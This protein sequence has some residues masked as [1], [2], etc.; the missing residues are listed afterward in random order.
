MA[1]APA[2]TLLVIGA[3]PKALALVAKRAILRQ[4]GFVV[5]RLLLIE[6]HDIAAH[7]AGVHGYT[8]GARM[9]GTAP[10]KDV[11]F[12]YDSTCWGDVEQNQQIDRDMQRFSWQTHLIETY[13]YAEWIDRGRPRPAHRQWAAYLRWVARK[14]EAEVLRA[15]VVGLTRTADGQRW[16]AT[17]QPTATA[18]AVTVAGDGLV[19]TGPGAPIHLPGQPLD[20]PRILDGRS[21]WQA[22]DQIA[23]ARHPVRVGIIGTGETA[24]ASI[25]ALLDALRDNVTIEVLS[26]RG[27]LYSRDEGFEENQLFSNPD[28]HRS[29]TLGKYAIADDEREDPT[30][31]HAIR[32]LSMTEADRREFVRRTDRGVFSVQAMQ[33]LTQFWNVRSIIGNASQIAATPEHVIVT[34]TYADRTERLAYDYVVVAR[35]FDALWFTT[36]FDA[37]TRDAL[38]AVSAGMTADEIEHA[39]ATDLAVGDFLPRLHLPMLA[40]V[41][42]GPGFPNLSCLG[43]LSDRILASYVTLPEEHDAPADVYSKEQ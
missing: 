31:T 21:I 1:S 37:P 34:S 14:S 16:L 13:K 11:G 17:C 38:S 25:V 3:G 19:I 6:Q 33:D 27:V 41:T 10:D 36:L 20:D 42:Q 5:P 43:L 39:I 30:H 32:W 12:P 15:T 40:G 7:W 8:D 26:P 29:V 22:I 18:D 35:G 9:L 4:R 2:T 24:A 23:E 28:P